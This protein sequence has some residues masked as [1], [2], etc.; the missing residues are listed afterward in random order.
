MAAFEDCAH[1]YQTICMER[2]EGI[3]QMTFPTN[4]YFL[5]WGILPHGEFPLVFR[6]IGSDPD[7]RVVIMT[8]TGAAFSGPPASAAAPARSSSPPL[9]RTARRRMAKCGLDMTDRMGYAE[10]LGVSSRQGL[11]AA[12][13]GKR[14]EHH[15]IGKLRTRVPLPARNGRKGP[16]DDNDASNCRLGETIEVQN[17]GK[18]WH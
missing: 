13:L 8:G 4:G 11:G 17:T 5:L 18:N 3:L 7:N 9:R 14:G 12:G 16:T 15:G 6:D 2:R 1:K 10:A